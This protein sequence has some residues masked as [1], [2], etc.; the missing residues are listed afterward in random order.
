MF[1]VVEQQYANGFVALVSEVRHGFR[2]GSFRTESA[3]A[4][5]QIGSKHLPK[6][7]VPFVYVQAFFFIL[8]VL[9]P[10]LLHGRIC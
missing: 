4:R 6:M 8:G 7:S 9:W 5:W 2:Y 1:P 10:P 3:P